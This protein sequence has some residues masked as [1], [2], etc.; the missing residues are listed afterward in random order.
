M[1]MANGRLPP[2]E[3]AICTMHLVTKRL[4]V[5]YVHAGEIEQSMQVNG[6]EPPP[7]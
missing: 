4:P 3:F 2:L 6:S 1:R 5:P 7:P